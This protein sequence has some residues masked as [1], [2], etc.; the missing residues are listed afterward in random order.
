MVISNIAH[1]IPFVKSDLYVII[2]SKLY[3][4]TCTEKYPQRI[5]EIFNNGYL[6]MGTWVIFHF[7]IFVFL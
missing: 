5:Y 1:M 3:V 4:C 6:W 2:L 7:V